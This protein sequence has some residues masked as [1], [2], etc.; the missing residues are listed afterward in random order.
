MRFLAKVWVDFLNVL[1]F[2]VLSLDVTSMGCH[3]LKFSL[4]ADTRVK[5][6]VKILDL[7]NPM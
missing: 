5:F 7:C 2:P 3:T 1:I 6:L 4:D